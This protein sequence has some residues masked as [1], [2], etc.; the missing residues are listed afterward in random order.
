MRFFPIKYILIIILFLG[1]VL[2]GQSFKAYYT[3]AGD[4]FDA[5]EM[6]QDKI[7]GK[8]ADL[9]IDYGKGS[10]I[11]FSR[12]TSYLPVWT[13]EDSVWKFTKFIERVGDG[14]T[15]RPDILSRYSH[16]RL[17]ESTPQ[18]LI[19][20]WRYFPNFNNVEWDGVVDEYFTFFQ[21]GI[22]SRKFKKGQK[23]IDDWNNDLNVIE[24][25]YKL[26]EKG[27]S[28]ISQT[29]DSI[30]SENQHQWKSKNQIE[31]QS[32]DIL[33]SFSFN[34]QEILKSNKVLEEISNKLYDVAGHKTV[35]KNGV[36]GKALHFDGYYSGVRLPQI[37]SSDLQNFTVSSYIALGAYPFEIAPIVH[38]SVWNKHGFYLGIDERGYPQF[39]LALNSDWISIVAD[40][41][42]DL[43]RWY[44][45]TATF[46]QNDGTAILY[47][48]GEQA[49]IFKKFNGQISIG[50]NDLFIG[51]NSQKMPDIQG[52]IR[53]GKWSSMYGI[54]GLLDEIKI[55]NRELNAEEIYDAYKN[56]LHN[57]DELNSP[58][59]MARKMPVN[60]KNQ[61]SAKFG[62]KYTKLEY[63]ETWDNLWRVSDHPDVVISFDEIPAKIVAWRGTSYGPYFVTE[64][65][66][67][68]GD[69]S[70][71]DYRLIEHPGE[72]EGCLEH[73]S[74]K[75]C[76]H[77]HIRIIE[78]TNARVV[79]HWRYGL[80]DSRYN[81][82]P[83][84]EG[85]G[86]W[87]DEYWTI[88]P[89]GVAIRDVARGI[90]FG[91]GWVET[92]FLSAPGT[93][94]EENLELEA[95]TIMNE[96]EIKT[97][98]WENDSPEGIFEDVIATMVNSKSSYKMFNLYPS[99][100]SVE[101]FSGHNKL[102][103]FHWWNHWPVSQITSDG[104]GAKAADRMA[105]SSLVWGA[106][107]KHFLLYGFTNQPIE[108]LKDLANSWNSPPQIIR[109]SNNEELKYDQRQR[110]Y[111]FNDTKM[112]KFMVHADV[113]SPLF[114]PCFIIK[115]WNQNKTAN[116]F[117][118]ETKLQSGK[119]FRQGTVYGTDGSTNL[120][121][122]LKCN[123]KNK[124]TIRFE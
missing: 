28:L 103:K 98:S 85:W 72:A 67:W 93:K 121:L 99:G 112:N 115:N 26:G 14:N 100:S 79:L 23:L 32:S 104:R 37:E 87:T 65:G 27:I 94:P 42:L 52:R 56:I 24:A 68:I 57:S 116:L 122:W 97:L 54:D 101:I 107:T 71:E 76:R 58:D 25:T 80:V 7:F 9:V 75:Q 15:Q 109:I 4:N 83:R 33:L 44:N 39:N 50:E 108:T 53:R 84:N 82:A 78:N 70:N 69:Q 10:K 81:F 2:Y 43:F 60:P 55:Y 113:N 18:A 38:Q 8:Y 12:N 46:N 19:V 64:N 123:F 1:A 61:T 5:L 40:S 36:V 90:V 41:K 51:I 91:D 3:N 110:A 47:V 66:L 111:I 74:D 118:N 13:V 34:D 92:M 88:Y 29:S 62:A 17:I 105:H 86:G 59:M 89:D 20:H 73:M 49:G 45:I 124:K 119:D 22:V 6:D 63:Y 48:N 21:S 95:L 16:V 31:N 117:V 30:I 77:S 96:D 11:L 35:I 106:P 120:I 114:N 102:S